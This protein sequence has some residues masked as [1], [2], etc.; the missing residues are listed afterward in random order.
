MRVKVTFPQRNA[1]KGV[2]ERGH[3]RSTLQR[4]GFAGVRK[5]LRAIRAMCTNHS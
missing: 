3:V 5:M 4:H 2:F 1:I